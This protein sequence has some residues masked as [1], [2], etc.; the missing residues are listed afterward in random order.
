MKLYCLQIDDVIP[1]TR[2]HGFNHSSPRRSH[3][4]S[5]RTANSHKSCRRAVLSQ[6]RM[7]HKPGTLAPQRAHGSMPLRRGSFRA[8]QTVAGQAQPQLRPLPATAPQPEPGLAPSRRQALQRAA[9]YAAAAALSPCM[10]D[11]AQ[12]EAAAARVAEV[13]KGQKGERDILMLSSGEWYHITCTEVLIAHVSRSLW[14]FLA[15]RMSAAPRQ[16]VSLAGK[17]GHPKCGP[18]SSPDRGDGRGRAARGRGD[19]EVR[20]RA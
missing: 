7:S 12:P 2:H 10:W 11:V 18:A 6:R 9:L 20:V 15:T 4:D 17:S 1:H 5:N 19:R 3:L 16:T 13:R 14:P 8:L